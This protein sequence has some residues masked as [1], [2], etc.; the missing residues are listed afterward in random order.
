MFGQW[1]YNE[2]GQKLW[3]LFLLLIFLNP[4]K[5]PVCFLVLINYPL[6]NLIHCFNYFFLLVVDSNKV[7]FW[8]FSWN[9]LDTR[10]SVYSWVASRGSIQTSTS[11]IGTSTSSWAATTPSTSAKTKNWA[12]ENIF[13]LLLWL[14]FH[15]VINL[16]YLGDGEMWDLTFSS[17][18]RGFFTYF[19]VCCKFT[20]K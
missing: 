13:L 15:F 4:Y 5:T 3:K 14:Y 19:F 11:L 16:L 6:N 12:F 2:E 18:K 7:C 1:T 10:F 9:W 8:I 17:K 20:S